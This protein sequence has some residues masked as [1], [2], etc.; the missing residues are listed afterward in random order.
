MAAFTTIDDPEAH[1]QTVGYTGNGTADKAITLPGTTAMAPDFVW[2]KNREQTDSYCMFDV[3]RGVTKVL[4]SDTNAA[5]ATD[6]DTLDAFQ[7]DGFRVDGDDKVNSSSEKFVA[8]CWKAGGS[9]SANTDGGEDTSVSANTAA[10][11][12]IVKYTQEVAQGSVFTAG[13]GLGVAPEFIIIKGYEVTDQWIAG[14]KSIGFDK[15]FYLDLNNAASDSTAHFNDTAPTATVFTLGTNSAFNEDNTDG[16]CY[17]WA[18][19]QG[20]SKFGKYVGNGSADGTFVFTGFRP[21]VVLL[22]VTD[23]TGNWYIFDNARD[24]YNG[25][26]WELYLDIN[27]EEGANYRLDFLANGFKW[28]NASNPVNGTGETMFYGAWAEAPF[29][30][31]N[32]VPSTAR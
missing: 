24:G 16:I 1:Y 13:H 15:G 19:I 14:H 8:W 29:V 27:N 2:I 9:A 17:C 20:F 4:H 6:A 32:G 18:S 25:D 26:N 28:R 7:S 11:F 5:E 10:G 23:A 22:K 31:S 30:N 12:S 21:A 3:I